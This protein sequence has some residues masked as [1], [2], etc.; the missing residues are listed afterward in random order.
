MMLRKN[1]WVEK[2]LV[3]GS[4]G[5][6]ADIVYE[7]GK[8]PPSLPAL[9]LVK[10][11]NFQGPFLKDDLFPVFT[12]TVTWKDKDT[13]CKRRQ[14]PISVAYALTIH[15]AQGL[16]LDKAEIDIGKK[17]NLPGLSYVALSRVR[18]L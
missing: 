11:D 2:G 15:T 16:T 4:L 13:E 12:T 7:I 8:R 9:V 14:F 10:F 18:S 17:E 1:L 3:N 6:V 5:T